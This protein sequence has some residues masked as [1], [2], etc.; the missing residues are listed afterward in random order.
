MMS[1]KKK[2]MDNQK[3]SGMDVSLTVAQ[4]RRVSLHL[5]QNNT[6]VDRVH[7]LVVRMLE[8]HRDSIVLVVVVAIKD[9]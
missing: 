2:T 5:A 1:A 4:R 7:L 8:V 3:N 6:I 9:C